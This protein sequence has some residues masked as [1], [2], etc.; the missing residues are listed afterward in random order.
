MKAKEEE[1][2]TDLQVMHH[3]KAAEA[4]VVV[5]AEAEVSEAEMIPNHTNKRK[6]R[7]QLKTNST[8]YLVLPQPRIPKS[9]PRWSTTTQR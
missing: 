3:I 1:V 7:I 8:V 4:A 2:V 6:R 9:K 5:E